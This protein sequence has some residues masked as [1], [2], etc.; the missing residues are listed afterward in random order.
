MLS[1]AAPISPDNTMSQDHAAQSAYIGNGGGNIL[2]SS[3][4]IDD[5]P[6]RSYVMVANTH[7]KALN[8]GPSTDEEA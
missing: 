2:H 5:S 8:A 6:H 1:S 3:H 7:L 4:L